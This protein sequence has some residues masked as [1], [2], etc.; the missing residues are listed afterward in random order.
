MPTLSV[1]IANY[2]HGKLLP[3]ALDAMLSQSRPPREIIVIDDGSRDDSL[4]VM[5][6]YA[7]RHPL[8]RVV[9][10]EGNRGVAYTMNRG[11]A[12][13]R[14]DLVYLAAADDQVVPGFFARA[15]D[16]LSEHPGAGLVFGQ[17]TM[18]SDEGQPMSLFRP[19]A[20]EQDCF[21]NP[22]QYLSEFLERELATFSLCGATIY[23]RNAYQEA[24]GYREELGHWMDTFLARAVG[25]RY[26]GCYIAAPVMNWFVSESGLARG[27]PVERAL[28][29]AA[30]AAELMRSPEFRDLFPENHVERW[31][32]A[33][34][35]EIF[36]DNIRKKHARLWWWL[37][38]I[39][40]KRVREAVVRRLAARAARRPSAA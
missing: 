18:M 29:I 26:G 31:T 5:S 37:D 10:N 20:W 11:V 40:G 8:V 21:V 36:R 27:T 15:H 3:R 14:G 22:S 28:A 2:N 17:I 34:R 24:G 12:L 23:C 7:G 35:A 16:L 25:L 9:S 13:A 38:R 32:N 1:I 4:A 6:Q 30:R 19:S 39:G 33:Y